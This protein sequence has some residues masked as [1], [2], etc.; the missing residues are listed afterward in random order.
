MKVAFYKAKGI[1]GNALVRW[2]TK[3]AYSHCELVLPSG[4]CVSSSLMDGG[5]RTK[6]IDLDPAKWDV[7]DVPWAN[8]VTV[9]FHLGRTDGQPYDWWAMIGSMLF[10]RRSHATK[11]AFCSEWCAEALALPNPE[12][13]NPQTLYELCLRI[14][15]L[16]GHTE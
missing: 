7:I 13:H 2:W 11:A 10:N 3:S 6:M 12:I 14:N 8:E 4:E 15:A 16:T 9:M 5:V 1:V